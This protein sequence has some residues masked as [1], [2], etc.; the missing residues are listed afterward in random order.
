MGGS[1]GVCLLFR[2][3]T[4]GGI[5]PFSAGSVLPGRFT[6]VLSVFRLRF[7][8]CFQLQLQL[9][10]V[11]FLFWCNNGCFWHGIHAGALSAARLQLHL[12][13]HSKLSLKI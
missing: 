3:C 1:V 2:R 4:P 8:V 7:G 10:Y 11:A 6:A 13:C 5:R 9:K 12:Q